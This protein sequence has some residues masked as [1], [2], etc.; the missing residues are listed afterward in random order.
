MFMLTTIWF[1]LLC[2]TE[3]ISHVNRKMVPG[4]SNVLLRNIVKV[5]RDLAVY[6]CLLLCDNTVILRIYDHYKQQNY[7]GDVYRSVQGYKSN[8]NFTTVSAW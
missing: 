4:T 5:N 7:Y 2:A 6:Y 8:I 1:Y 3:S